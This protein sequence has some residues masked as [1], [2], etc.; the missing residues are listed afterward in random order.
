L[1]FGFWGAK[2]K[3]KSQTKHTFILQEGKRKGKKIEGRKGWLAGWLV[4]AW[5]GRRA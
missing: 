4:H 5:C 3:A 1:A 2:A